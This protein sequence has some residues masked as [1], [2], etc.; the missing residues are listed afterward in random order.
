[1]RLRQGVFE[2]RFP[3]GA[4]LRELKL[5]RELSVS[6]ATVREAL[7]RLEHAGLVTR[8]PNIGATVTRLSPKDVRERV[9]LRSILEVKA[10]QAAAQRMSSAEFEELELRLSTLNAAVEA[11]RYYESAHADVEFHRYVWQCSGDDT[12]CRH[13]ELLVIPLFAFVA[14][15]RSQGLERL[16]TVV[17]AH[18]PLISALRSGD[19]QQIQTE[20]ERSATSA[21]TL[22][23]GNGPERAVAAAFGFLER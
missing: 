8:K 3:P 10:A 13:L 17:E 21:Y 6:Q 9:E 5:A 11:N 14:I 1:M 2:G 19:P 20:F 22:F 12:L 7:Q 18:R 16:V 23:L 4:P 15:M